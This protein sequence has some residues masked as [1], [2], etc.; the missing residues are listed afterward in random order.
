MMIIN[1]LIEAQQ[2]LDEINEPF[3]ASF[4]GMNIVCNPALNENEVMIMAG[5]KAYKVIMNNKK[6]LDSKDKGF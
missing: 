2:K 1:D 4:A 3:Y 5:A 6:A